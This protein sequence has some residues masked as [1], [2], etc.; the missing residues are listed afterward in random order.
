MVTPTPI[1]AESRNLNFYYS[2][3]TRAL[4]SITMPLH[5]KRIT[6][7]IGPSG[8]GKSTFLRCFN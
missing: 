1:K 3:G 8:C 4:K 7:L 2:N 6:A 5:E